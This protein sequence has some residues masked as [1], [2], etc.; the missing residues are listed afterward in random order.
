MRDMREPLR[1]EHELSTADL[2]RTGTPAGAADP[3]R[4]DAVADRSGAVHTTDLGAAPLFAPDEAERFRSEWSRIQADFVDEPGPSVEQADALV[5]SVMKRLAEI[6]AEERGRLENQWHGSGDISTEDLRL[7][8][9]RY[10]SFF[11]R[12]L[13]V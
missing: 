12:L 3:G 5:A 10:R 8:L 7:A 11:T 6:F 13:S 9:Q 2:A 4:R 1:G